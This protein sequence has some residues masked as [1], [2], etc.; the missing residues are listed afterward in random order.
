MDN[1]V[2]LI[3]ISESRSHCLTSQETFAFE[4]HSFGPT[5]VS[6][7]VLLI[8]VC[9]EYM[10]HAMQTSSDYIHSFFLVRTSN[11]AAEAELSYIFLRC[12]SEN[13]FEMLLTL[14]GIVFQ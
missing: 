13:V 5:L 4:K 7:L 10:T 14:H 6:C 2:K 8:A 3:K 1:N 11:I 12:E 9:Y